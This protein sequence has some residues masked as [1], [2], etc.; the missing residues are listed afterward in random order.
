MSEK[1]LKTALDLIARRSVPENIDLWQR[2]VAQQNRRYSLMKLKKH[3]FAAILIALSL[4]LL[5]SGAVYAIGRSLGFIPGIGFVDRNPSTLMLQEPVRTNQNGLQLTVVQVVADREKTAIIYTVDASQVPPPAADQAPESVT[6]G[7]QSVPDYAA[8][9]LRLPDGQI[10]PGGSV[11]PDPEQPYDLNGASR[12][13]AMDP[14]LPQGIDTFTLVLG[15][16]QAE[17]A[18]HL[19]P[20]PDGTILPVS[21]ALPQSP[22]IDQEQTVSAVEPTVLPSKFSLG[23]DSYVELD[24]GYILVG[25][26]QQDPLDD[27]KTLPLSYFDLT[28]TDANGNPVEFQEVPDSQGYWPDEKD[29]SREY[30]VIKVLGKDPAWPIKVSHLPSIELASA[31]VAEFQIDLGSNPQAGQSLDLN[32]EVPIEKIGN[33]HVASV[34]LFQGTAPLEDPNAFGLD[35]LITNGNSESPF[36]TLADKAH[37]SQFLGGGGGP[38][39]YNVQIFYPGGYQPSGLISITVV[40]SGIQNDPAVTVDWKP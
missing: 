21:T 4:I 12:F 3:P 10:L 18:V 40:Y 2:I 36:V 14:P 33:L 26:R 23:I 38:E 5:A 19:V 24:D 35:F 28:L 39:G 15:C 37:N 27:R 7:C 11:G 29:L 31:E 22:Q 13:I 34:S 30:W 20:A 16:S 17:A 25:Y 9:S 32:M 1:G 6:P 8:H